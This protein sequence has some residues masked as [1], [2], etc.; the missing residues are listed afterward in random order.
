MKAKPGVPVGLATILGIAGSVLAI[1]TAVVQSL[2]TNEAFLNGQGSKAG[3]IAGILIAV[4][5]GGR[6]YQGANPGGNHIVGEVVSGASAVL[7]AEDPQ[8]H[9]DPSLT[10]TEVPVLGNQ[11]NL[12]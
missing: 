10:T 5:V 6:M 12:A 7:E 2:S 1:G 9:L 4:T 3:W 11:A 8:I